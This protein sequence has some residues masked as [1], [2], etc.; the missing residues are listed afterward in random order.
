MEGQ[1]RTV[2]SGL[3]TSNGGYDRLNLWYQGDLQVRLHPYVVASIG[4]SKGRPLAP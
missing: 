1:R 4:A 3:V 2:S